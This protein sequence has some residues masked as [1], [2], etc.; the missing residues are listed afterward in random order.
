MVGLLRVPRGETSA[1]RFSPMRGTSSAPSL[2]R[3]LACFKRYFTIHLRSLMAAQCRRGTSSLSRSLTSTSTCCPATAEKWAKNK[4]NQKPS[5][6]SRVRSDAKRSGKAG[7]MRNKINR[8]LRLME[9]EPSK[10]REPNQ[11]HRCVVCCCMCNAAYQTLIKN[12]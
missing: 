10:E 12:K 7:T 9:C 2:S 4:H 1:E 3:L 8:D 6:R 5:H 11:K